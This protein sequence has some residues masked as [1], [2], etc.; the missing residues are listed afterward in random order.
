MSENGRKEVRKIHVS[1]YTTMTEETF[2]EHCAERLLELASSGAEFYTGGAGGMD[3]LT[4]L[5]LLASGV[6]PTRI[7]VYDKKAEN[8]AL[9]A[10]MHHVNG[11]ETFTERDEALTQVTTE[12]FAAFH[13][14]GGAGSGTFA[15]LVRRKFGVDV[16]RGVQ[17]LGQESVMPWRSSEIALIENVVKK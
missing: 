2:R 14:Y 5:F 7:H 6:D 11:F 9:H 13:Q 17:K 1:G 3:R 10:D 4:Q 16:A 8:N 15:N 12:D